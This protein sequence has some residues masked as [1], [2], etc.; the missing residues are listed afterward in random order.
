[1][2]VDLGVGFQSLVTSFDRVSGFAC[3]RF[4]LRTWDFA[5]MSRFR[6]LEREVDRGVTERG[7]GFEWN[8]S[9]RIIN[10]KVLSGE[11]TRS[12]Q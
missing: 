7:V 6:M 3:G 11:I 2:G 5:E 12:R 4:E 10:P 1:M 8:V 9:C